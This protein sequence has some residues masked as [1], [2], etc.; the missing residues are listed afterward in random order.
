M[1]LTADPALVAK[2]R[3]SGNSIDCTNDEFDGSVR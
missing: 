3:V 2:M 1:I